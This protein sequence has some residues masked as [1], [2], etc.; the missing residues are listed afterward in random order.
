MD[1]VR[2]N[3]SSTPSKEIETSPGYARS[4]MRQNSP[5]RRRQPP[6]HSSQ[7]PY[8]CSHGLRSLKAG[9]VDLDGRLLSQHAF[10]LLVVLALAL[11]IG[12][13][14]SHKLSLNSRLVWYRIIKFHIVHAMI[15]QHQP[16]V[17]VFKRS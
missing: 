16:G 14:E 17:S 1:R 12:S 11:L 8:P 5:R 6:R 3:N 7:L 15:W 4:V 9:L 13:T 10:E 2:E